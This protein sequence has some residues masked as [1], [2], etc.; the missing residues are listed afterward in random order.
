MCLST[1]TT[2]ESLNKFSWKF[3]LGIVLKYV[4]SFQFWLNR[5]AVADFTWRNACVFVYIGLRLFS[6]YLEFQAMNEAH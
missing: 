3:V 6:I 4:D 2:G 5:I 1:R